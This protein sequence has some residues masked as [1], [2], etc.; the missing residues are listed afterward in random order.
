MILL[1]ALQI[2]I[3]TGVIS[4]ILIDN[5]QD[6][7]EIL[8]DKLREEFNNNIYNHLDNYFNTVSIIIEYNKEAIITDMY[9]INNQD[10]LISYFLK[11]IMLFPNISS[12]YFGNPQGGIANAGREPDGSLYMI[13]SEDFKSGAFRKYSIDENHSKGGIIDEFPDFDAR[14]RPWY[15]NAMN[16]LGQVWSE[17]YVLF[18]SHDMVIS[19]SRAVY[20][21]EGRFS[22]IISID[23]FLSIISNYLAEIDIS[24]NSQSYIIDQEGLLIASS[25]QIQLFDYDSKENRYRRISAENS[26]CTLIRNS[27]VFLLGKYSDYKKIA[28]DKSLKFSVENEQFYINISSFHLSDDIEWSIITMMPRADIMHQVYI[29]E[30]RAYVIIG[31]AVLISL[32][33]AVL[34][35]AWISRPILILNKKVHDYDADNARQIQSE[36]F[37]AE[38]DDL[39]NAFQ[40]LTLRLNDTLEKIN[41]EIKEKNIAK[42]R[43]AE[44][45]EL[46]KI[47]LESIGDGVITGDIQGRIIMLNNMAEILTGWKC[48]EVFLKP[49]DTVFNVFDSINAEKKKDIIS[50]IINKGIS[51]GFPNDLIL[52]TKEN[53]ELLISGSG[54]PIRDYDGKVIGIVIVF[55]DITEK[56][57][58]LENAR[59]EQKMQDFELLA[60]KI[61]HDFNNLLSGIFGFINIAKIKSEKGSDIS[62]NLDKAILAFAKAK[63]LINKLEIFS[64]EKDPVK[65]SGDIGEVLKNSISKMLTGSN[66]ISRI[67]IADDLIKCSFD[68]GQIS[69]AFSNIIANAKE[70][71]GARG[72]IDICA[73]NIRLNENN[74][75]LP[76]GDYIQIIIEDNGPGIPRN[77][78]KYLFDPYFT[79]KT[80]KKG[81]GLPIGYSIIKKHGGTIIIDSHEAKG[82][83][84][85]IYIPAGLPDCSAIKEEQRGLY[86]G[87]GNIVI[88]D[89]EAYIIEMLSEMLKSIGFDVITSR[90]GDQLLE[91][92]KELQSGNKIK[93]VILDLIIHGGRGGA[94]II[95]SVRELY[96]DIPVFVSSGYT[97]DPIMKNPAKY[98]FTASIKKPF[99][100]EELSELFGKYLI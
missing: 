37:I 73:D 94:D 81:L 32:F 83:S 80:R 30:N 47:T 95:Q 93:A 19:S 8:A 86:Q 64:R 23:L 88:M 41:N 84:I 57:K 9:D 3:V 65:I 15:I 72:I 31:I 53:K 96:P 63:E 58:L 61:S 46:L 24:P 60:G 82:T 79:S 55:R 90:N 6:A 29:N 100:I 76:S 56:E 21:N 17:V 49:V 68:P 35:S 38:I 1:F 71:L 59:T 36:S 70:S 25:R 89:D 33:L 51:D 52:K 27:A 14:T 20:D 77:T 48:E 74:L 85:K 97:S 7:V 62:K 54:S 40:S 5:S 87:Y 66:I 98:G 99:L 92:L 67:D 28:S 2:I 4:Y 44:E 22:G 13:K 39:G 12:I 11:Q 45:K 34:V 75:G 78:Q 42:K 16:S 91:K 10:Q 43:L 18:T 26:P 50:P 69:Q